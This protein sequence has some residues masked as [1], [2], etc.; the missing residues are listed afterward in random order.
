MRCQIA[1]FPNDPLHRSLYILGKRSTDYQLIFETVQQ[2]H[3][4]L[5]H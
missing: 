4:D 2:F 3:A 5:R 1:D